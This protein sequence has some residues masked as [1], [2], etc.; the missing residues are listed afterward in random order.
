MKSLIYILLFASYISLGAY[1]MKYELSVKNYGI[2]YQSQCIMLQNVG[3]FEIAP[4]DSPEIRDYLTTVNIKRPAPYCQ[5]FVYYCF[6]M[7]DSNN[8]PIP[9]TAVANEPYNY[10]KKIGIKV[11]YEAKIHDLIVWKRAKSWTG[12]VERIFA[13]NKA[14]WVHTVGANTSNNKY[15]DQRDG[16]GVYIKIRN[17]YH[18]LGRLNIRGLIGF[19]NEL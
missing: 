9:R 8:I 5:A 15:G 2:L 13:I 12:H 19:K 6:Y 4:N 1:P 17:I 14:G 16:E 7:A 10:A 3:V 18:P 11:K